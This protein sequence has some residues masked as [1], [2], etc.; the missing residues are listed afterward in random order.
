MSATP[1]VTRS[2][3]K[4]MVDFGEYQRGFLFF[5]ME[6]TEDERRGYDERFALTDVADATEDRARHLR[7]QGDDKGS[8]SD[9][10]DA[11]PR[12]CRLKKSPR[13]MR[14]TSDGVPSG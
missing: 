10:D 5:F 8:C 3:S 11:K 9:N 2:V 12:R 4:L 7:Y 1:N 13:K 14:E 6:E